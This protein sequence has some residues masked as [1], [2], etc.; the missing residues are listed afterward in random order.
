MQ[1]SRIFAFFYVKCSKKK[2]YNH[3][4]PFKP[5]IKS[6]I[7]IHF[8][9]YTKNDMK[10]KITTKNANRTLFP[11]SFSHIKN[12]TKGNGKMIITTNGRE[13]E[14]ES[15]EFIDSIDRFSWQEFIYFTEI[16]YKTEDGE[17][18]LETMWKLNPEWRKDEVENGVLT[19]EDLKEK[20][21]YR[22]MSFEEA[23]AWLDGAVYG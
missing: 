6:E 14:K 19:E 13:Y 4:I 1:N 3:V 17:Y 15:L 18:I 8:Y 7:I 5:N 11:L 21:E 10:E 16:L 22:L 20:D 12:K 23:D 2:Y 9:I